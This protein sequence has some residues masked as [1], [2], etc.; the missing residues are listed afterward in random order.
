MKQQYNLTDIENTIIEAI[1]TPMTKT[2]RSGA[3]GVLGLINP[4]AGVIAGIGDNIL[5][6]YRT[7]KFS[8][9]LNGLSSG[10]NLEARLNELYTYVTSSKDN[11]ITVANLFTKTINAECPKVCF[12][13]GLILADHMNNN[14]KFTQD[15][16]IVCKALENA[17]E[18]DLNN[19]KEIMEKYLKPISDGNRIVLPEELGKSNKFTLTCEWAV[20]N[21]LFTS[22]PTEWGDIEEEYEGLNTQYHESKPASVL[23]EYI[24]A[25]SQIWNY[26]ENN[27]N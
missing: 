2:I 15:E 7:Y 24:K 4:V 13:Y 16:L 19:F 14:T 8:H 27:Q 18:F 10:L 23:M 3:I 11:A 6:D 9:L 1:D 25:A 5:S 17:T 12:I 22:H 21:R 26:G 20:Y